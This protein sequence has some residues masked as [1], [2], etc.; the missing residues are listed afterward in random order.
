MT[1]ILDLSG[2]AAFR[3]RHLILVPLLLVGSLAYAAKTDVLVLL[4]GDHITGEVKSVDR[5]KLTFKTDDIGTLSVEWDK[6]AH[7]ESKQHLQ[8]ETSSGKLYFGSLVANDKSG[9]LRVVDDRMGIESEVTI[10]KTVRI[11]VL[12]V[13]KSFKDRLDGSF[14]LGY[15]Y[16]KSTASEQLS[17]DF[18]VS[19]SDRRRRWSLSGSALQSTTRD[20]A[21]NSAN[22]GAEF[23]RLRANR[24]FWAGTV[25][26]EKNDELG[27]DLRTLVGGGVGRYIIQSNSQELG[28]FSGLAAAE[29]RFQDGDSQTSAELVFGLSYDLFYFDSPKVDISTQLS[30]FPSLTVSGRV[31]A[32]AELSFSYE[33][34]KDLYAQLTFANDYDNKPQS[35]GAAENDYSVVTSLGFTF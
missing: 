11:N 8:I 14:D 35:L 20:S 2:L 10:E 16:T 26:F 22:L 25:T 7:L 30:A 5:G 6:V 13:K 1:N 12:D 23:R 28:L 31:R 29:E 32:S 19:H 3:A 24:W 21:S 18:D 4:N 34:V 33:I 9:A 15:S 17:L 27:L